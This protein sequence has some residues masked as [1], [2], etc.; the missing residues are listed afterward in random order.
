MA[1]RFIQKYSY[2]FGVRWLLRRLNIFPNAYYNYLRNRKK[3]KSHK[4]FENLLK[5]DFY[6]EEPNKIWCTD[7]TYLKLTDG[8]FRYNCSILDL[9][10]RSVV[11][12]ITAREMTSEL[13][14]KALEKALRKVK[15]IR[16]KIIL[17]SD[18]G[19]QYSSKKFVEYCNST[20]YE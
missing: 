13:A 14:I 10:D 16:N 11:S 17:H 20:K 2:L 9:Y 15:K 8:S 6:V 3:G 1:Y 7:F 18:Q 19:S 12:S 4:I 5:Q